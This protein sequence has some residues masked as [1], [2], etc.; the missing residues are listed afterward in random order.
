MRC[1]QLKSMRIA[2]GAIEMGC[3][4]GV[5]YKCR[6]EKLELSKVDSIYQDRMEV[7]LKKVPK[8]EKKTLGDRFDDFVNMYSDREYIFTSGK[9]YTYSETKQQ[10]DLLAKGLI[11]IGIKNREHV[12]MVMANYPEA[13]F[14]KFGVAKVGAVN[15]PF[16]YR[17]QKDELKYVMWQSDTVC[18]ITMDQWGSL[19]Y[20]DML[21]NLCSEVFAGGKSSEFPLL[22]HIVVFS[23]SGKKYPGTIDYYDFIKSGE[24]LSDQE[25]Q[26]TQNR[27]CYP[28]EVVDILYTSG[29]TGKPKGVM[30][31]HDML[32]RKSY[33][34][35]LGRAIEDGRRMFVP[36]PLYHVFGYVE[37]ILAMPWVGGAILPQ[38][39]FGAKEALELIQNGRA[40]DII[41]VPTIAINLVDCPDI[42]NYD[43]SSLHYMY[44]AGAPAPVRLWE[45]M[46]RELGLDYL[47]TGYGMTE[48]SSAPIQSEVG[49]NVEKI[50]T[51]CGRN[52]P[53]GAAGLPEFGYKCIEYK[54][55][56][57]VTGKEL[58]PGEEGE[59]VCRGPVVTNGYYN[60]PQETSEV[61]DKDGWLRTGDLIR[62]HEDGYFEIT[63]RSKELYRIVGENVAP[64]DIEEV[65]STYPKVSQVY[66]V[67]V[68]DIKLGEVGY[69][70]ID[71]NSGET[72]SEQ[73]ILDYARAKL[74]GYKVPKFIKFIN[75]EELPLTSTGKV[76]KFLLKERAIKELC[77]D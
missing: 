68:P 31:T 33:A 60:K 43:L 62:I 2:K 61:I 29:T 38:V 32:W 48:T 40:N 17:T 73:E 10:V 34:S 53:A 59:L 36:L 50:A 30:L 44:C 12:A 3:S 27:V 76:Q 19:N 18:L 56:D 69:A 26:S 5:C 67:G 70:F 23:P 65:I 8:W 66:I 22:R 55:V 4:C 41:C 37:G 28:D 72:C 54:V 74:A 9:Q 75:T 57:T 46:I 77:L 20:I 21:K 15:V 52:I 58:L 35:T 49:I 16:N 39:T 7:N 42:K 51:R 6:I 47:N 45:R 14:I 25:M 24:T 1:K 63:G 71:L 64:K 13:V 11:R